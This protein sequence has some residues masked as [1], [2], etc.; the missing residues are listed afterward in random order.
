MRCVFFEPRHFPYYK[1][2]ASDIS[3]TTSLA[4][5]QFRHR[6]EPITSPT[7]SRCAMCFGELRVAYRDDMHL[8]IVHKSRRK[9]NLS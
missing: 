8:Q 5:T 3:G 4:T 2:R 9:P 7:P 6:I 1:C